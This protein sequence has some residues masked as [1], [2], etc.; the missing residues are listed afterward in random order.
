M[1]LRFYTEHHPEKVEWAKDVFL[2]EV[3]H[4]NLFS[5]APFPDLICS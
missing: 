1:K 5:T 3:N 4:V 2:R